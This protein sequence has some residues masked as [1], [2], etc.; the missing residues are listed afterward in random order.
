MSMPN[1][2]RGPLLGGVALCIG[3]E[4]AADVRDY[5]LGL[6]DVIA[7]KDAKVLSETKVDPETHGEIVIFVDHDPTHLQQLA[8]YKAAHRLTKDGCRVTVRQP[9]G[10]PYVRT[11]KEAAERQR[12]LCDR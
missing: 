1:S 2:S 4:L 12:A 11:W 10:Y 7:A 8:A 5:F 9:P 3:E 6:F